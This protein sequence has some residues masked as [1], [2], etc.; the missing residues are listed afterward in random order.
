MRIARE[1]DFNDLQYNCWDCEDVLEAV[2][3]ADMEDSLMDLLEDCFNE[4]IPTLTEVN[5]LLRFDGD[6]VLETLGIEE[7]D[8]E[9]DEEEELDD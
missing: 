1:F 3:N 6:W 9:D 8:D 2:A 7:D 4:E 5:D